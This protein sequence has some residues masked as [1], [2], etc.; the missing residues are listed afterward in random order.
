MAPNRD[1]RFTI[2]KVPNSNRAQIT[3]SDVRPSD[4]GTYWC[5]IEYPSSDMYRQLT[6][7]VSGPPDPTEA[8]PNMLSGVK[9]VSVTSAKKD[10]Q[11]GFNIADPKDNTVQQALRQCNDNS[12]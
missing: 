3:I 12:A 5:G 8:P 4:A 7:I 11:R 9:T 10:N 6:F 1:P 2:T